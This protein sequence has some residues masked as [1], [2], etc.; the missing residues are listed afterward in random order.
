MLLQSQAQ[1]A[2]L[3]RQGGDGGQDRRNQNEVR[4]FQRQRVVNRVGGAFVHN[5]AAHGHHG[6]GADDLGGARLQRKNAENHDQSEQDQ[7]GA[8]NRSGHRIGGDADGQATEYLGQCQRGVMK[9]PVQPG[10]QHRVPERQIDDRRRAQPPHAAGRNKACPTRINQQDDARH[11]GIS[12]HQRPHDAQ[13]LFGV[14]AEYP[15]RQWQDV[16]D[17]HDATRCKA[18]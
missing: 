17:R 9:T 10:A 7:G 16:L 8:V 3:G 12:C 6:Q 11:I 4:D 2:E 14:S 15:V 13:T 1:G 5:G 18:P